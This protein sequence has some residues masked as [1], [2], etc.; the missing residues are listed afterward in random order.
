[1]GVESVLYGVD[2]LHSFGVVDFSASALVKVEQ[3]ES[4][5]KGP[6]HKLPS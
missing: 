4:S 3:A 6:A 2:D 5:V 1:M